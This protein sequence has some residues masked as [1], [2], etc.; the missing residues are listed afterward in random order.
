MILFDFL[1][2]W[3]KLNKVDFDLNF[4]TDYVILDYNDLKISNLNHLWTD[5][6][7][8]ETQILTDD[9]LWK[10]ESDFDFS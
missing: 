9:Y 7:S 5:L 10:F 1:S 4:L 8:L 6:I 3:V 2:F